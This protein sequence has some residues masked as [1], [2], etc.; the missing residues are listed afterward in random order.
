FEFYWDNYPLNHEVSYPV[1][2]LGNKR[3]I[4][5]SAVRDLPILHPE[6]GNPILYSGRLDSI[7]HFAGAPYGFDEKTTTS[8][9]QTWSKK[10]SLRGQFLGYMWLCREN[11]I[12]LKGIVVRGVSILKT[13]YETQ[14]SINNYLDW[15]ID[16]WYT[17]TLHWINFAIAQW[18]VG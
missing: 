10:W 5:F 7:L 18:R 1:L 2:L 12:I 8:L 9:G 4:E 17:E 6:T 16:R 3:A 13:K 14:E 11:S 15:E